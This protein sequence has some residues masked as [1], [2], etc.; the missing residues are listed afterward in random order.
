M[1]Q[2]DEV[3]RARVHLP[4]SADAAYPPPLVL[5]FHGFAGSAV[6]MEVGSGM[7]TKADE[8]GFVAVY[9][10][11]TGFSAEWDL[12]GTRDIEFVAALLAALE[13]DVCFDPQRVYATGFSQGGGMAHLVGCHLADS[14]AA[15]A[16]VSGVYLEANS[17]SC[18]PARPVPVIG[19][20]GETDD[21][22]PLAGGRTRA[23]EEVTSV[24]EWAEDWA[25]RDG[26]DEG[27]PQAESAEG[28]RV[29]AL[30][31]NGCQASVELHVIQDGG[32]TWPGSPLD[33]SAE[34]ADDISATDLIWEFF[35]R[36]VIPAP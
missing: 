20:H 27:P 29:E 28:E 1:P 4:E 17:S 6:S 30:R 22:V 11:G 16:P 19:M 31:W 25:Q 8:A 14:V 32:H 3:R 10:E 2:G 33:A 26:C 18:A 13:E 7:S 21:V 36:H 5:V 9:P 15:I 34:T 12:L 24:E 35:D 23:G